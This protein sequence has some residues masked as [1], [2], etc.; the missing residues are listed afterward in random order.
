M[1][2]SLQFTEVDE[3]MRVMRTK[4]AHAL[5]SARRRDRAAFREAELNT[6]DVRALA[7]ADELIACAEGE[8][9][10]IFA[11]LQR[12]AAERG[13]EMG[14]EMGPEFATEGDE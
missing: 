10:S 14:A 6:A 12:E 9:M 7:M 11:F 5:R 4:R 1:K 2:K 3:K 13:P 8:G